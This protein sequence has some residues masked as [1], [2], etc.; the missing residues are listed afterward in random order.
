MSDERYLGFHFTDTCIY[1]A[2]AHTGQGDHL[3]WDLMKQ[4]GNELEPKW[5]PLFRE[6]V[7]NLYD[8]ADGVYGITAFSSACRDFNR[9]RYLRFDLHFFEKLVKRRMTYRDRRKL[10]GLFRHFRL[11]HIQPQPGETLVTTVV[12]EGLNAQQRRILRM[13]LERI[14]AGLG[15]EFIDVIEPEEASLRYLWYEDARLDLNVEDSLVLLVHLGYARTLMLLWDHCQ[16]VESSAQTLGMQAVDWH[17]AAR[18]ERMEKAIR[19]NGLPLYTQRARR[20][21]EL[22][23]PDQASLKIADVDVENSLYRKIV[24][25]PASDIASR[26]EVFA[27]SA[28]QQNQVDEI[29]LT[30]EGAAFPLIRKAI[31]EL[32]WDAPMRVLPHPS[33][34][35]ARGAA[36]KS[37]R[38]KNLNSEIR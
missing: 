25:E 11:L 10:S 17:V 29:L 37:W 5:R 24:R 35:A 38:A 32:S 18:V 6:A 8:N 27:R 1:V 20:A 2:E 12:I 3:C 9:E 28:D 16:T 36:S 4:E 22:S 19:G 23:E 7:P 26:L 14:T 15:L 13:L 34:A 30:G 31:E 21:F 33:H